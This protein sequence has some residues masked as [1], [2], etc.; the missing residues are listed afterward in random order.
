MLR[1]KAQEAAQ[2]EGQV[3]RYRARL[4]QA[5]G[6]RQHVK[7]LEEQNAKWVGVWIVCVWLGWVGWSHVS[8]SFHSLTV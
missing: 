5:S 6:A 8:V 3:E 1:C 4:E 2:L 7:D